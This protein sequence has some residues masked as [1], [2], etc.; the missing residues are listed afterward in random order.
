M[1]IGYYYTEVIT[2]QSNEWSQVLGKLS[3]Y[4]TYSRGERDHNRHLVSGRVAVCMYNRTAGVTLDIRHQHVT[5][6][7]YHI[8][9]ILKVGTGGWRGKWV[10]NH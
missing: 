10:P 2:D 7:R 4:I 3:S 9:V 6:G 1:Y 8:C 5:M